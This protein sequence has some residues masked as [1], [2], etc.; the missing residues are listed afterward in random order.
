MVVVDVRASFLRRLLLLELQPE[1]G[2]SRGGWSEWQ[3]EVQWVVGGKRQRHCGG[4]R[5]S[6][7]VS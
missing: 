4:R 5:L 6:V 3:A 1:V 2:Q 7:A